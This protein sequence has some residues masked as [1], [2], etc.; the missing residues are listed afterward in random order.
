MPGHQGVYAR[1]RGLWPGMTKCLWLWLRSR[2]FLNHFLPAHISL[3]HIRHRDAAALLLIGL[4]HG[5]QRA[6]D[7]DARAVE[8]MHEVRRAPLGTVARI[9]APR[10]EVAAVRAR[11]NLA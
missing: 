7:R 9:H 2:R 8:R 10:L 1:L 6:A 11:R 4:H 5:D 3:Q